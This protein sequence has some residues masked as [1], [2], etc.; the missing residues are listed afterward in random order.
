[1]RMKTAKPDQLGRAQLEL[2]KAE[3]EY[4]TALQDAAAKMKFVVDN[5]RS[6]RG[7]RVV[8]I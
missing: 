7:A 4:Q 1:M 5:V 6:S 2:Q 8:L 3:E